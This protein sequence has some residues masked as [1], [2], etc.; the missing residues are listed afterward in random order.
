MKELGYFFRAMMFLT[1]VPTPQTEN[2]EPDWLP[3]SVRYFPLVGLLV[4]VLSAAVLLLASQVW[5]GVLPA[6]LAVAA[7]AL[8]TGAFHED[9][10][11]DTVD[12]LGGYSREARLLIMTDSR[13]GTYGALAL[14]FCVALRVAALAALPPLAAAFALIAAH[15]GARFA[16]MVVM[17]LLPYAKNPAD[18]KVAHAKEPP[19]AAEYRPAIV[20]VLL[21]AAPLALTAPVALGAAAIA[22]AVLAAGLARLAR[23][24]IDGYTG[25]VLGATEQLFEV[26]FL[27]AVAA[28]ISV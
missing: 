16:A 9:G 27:L 10:L 28:V 25:D 5:N 20:F 6:L 22:G 14:G 3:H 21:A 26:G 2:I 7:S 13:I 15:A 8:V 17:T 23:R 12:S 18:G 11:A 4:G 19:G 1:I 24:L